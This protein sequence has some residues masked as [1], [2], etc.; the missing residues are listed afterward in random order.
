SWK[1]VGSIVPYEVPDIGPRIRR[2]RRDETHFEGSRGD[3]SQ[4][5]N[6]DGGKWRE[7]FLLATPRRA[8]EQKDKGKPATPQRP[9]PHP[10]ARPYS[11]RCVGRLRAH[12]SASQADSA[13]ARGAS[14]QPPLPH[15]Q[16]PEHPS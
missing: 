13:P 4:I 6:A 1:P 2:L 7:R 3:N 5:E 9:S 14:L 10:R 12:P 8:R 15:A 11:G 16:L